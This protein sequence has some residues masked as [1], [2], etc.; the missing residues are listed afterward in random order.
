MGL[1]YTC[2]EALM[3]LKTVRNNNTS[4]DCLFPPLAAFLPASQNKGSFLLDQTKTYCLSRLNETILPT[5]LKFSRVAWPF[6]FRAT[7]VSC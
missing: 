4:V 1:R 2:T 5:S 7:F 3:A 6:L